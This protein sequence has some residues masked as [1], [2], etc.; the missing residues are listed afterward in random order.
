M[1]KVKRKRYSAAK[2][3]EIIDFVKDYNNT[4][5]RGGQA[6]ASK[7]FKVSQLSIS[8]WLKGGGAS[9]KKASKKKGRSPE[10]SGAKGSVA[11]VLKR[12]TV[13][14]EKIATL[15]GEYEALKKQL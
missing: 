1:A 4:K 11:S 15:S 13:I 7:Q 6:A 2:K 5:G 3:Q 14:Q 10:S 9:K 12:M 8:N